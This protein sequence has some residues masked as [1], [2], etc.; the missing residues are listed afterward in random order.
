[1]DITD[2]QI[3]A[4]GNIQAVGVNAAVGN[5]FYIGG[6]TAC[7]FDVDGS[8]VIAEFLRCQCRVVAL[9]MLKGGTIDKGA[10]YPVAISFSHIR[11]VCGVDIITEVGP[12]SIFHR[13][14]KG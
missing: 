5:Q 6:Y 11:D 4:V 14:H 2:S 9:Y 3:A 12:G 10:V 1:M 13:L 7:G 8:V